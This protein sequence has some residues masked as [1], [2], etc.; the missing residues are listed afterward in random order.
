MKNRC[1]FRR[2]EIGL[3]GPAKRWRCSRKAVTRVQYE[4]TLLDKIET[5]RVCRQHANHM[6]TKGHIYAPTCR[7]RHELEEV[8]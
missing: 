8:S 1:E 4:D 6:L 7:N 5:V 3:D 2:T